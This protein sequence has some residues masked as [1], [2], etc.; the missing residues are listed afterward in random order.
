M[1]RMLYRKEPW[2]PGQKVFIASPAY[3][4]YGA[5]FAWSL[6]QTTAALARAGIPFELALYQG[7][8]HVDDSRNRLT[9]DFLNSDC[10]DMVFLDA[11]VGWQPSDFRALIDYERDIVAGVY[12]KKSGD[13]A[14]PVKLLPGEIWSDRDGLIEVAGAPTG[15]LRISRAV[16][17]TLAAR[18]Q[19]YN[20]KNDGAYATPL[21]FERQVHDMTRWGGDYVFCRKAREAGFSIYIDPKFRFEHSGEHTWTGNVGAWLR[22]RAGIG[23]LSGLTAVAKGR[24]TIDDIID[25]HD[26]WANPFAADPILL[27]GL[28]ALARAAKGPIL[29][30]G[31]G[32][33]TLVMAAAN[34]AVRVVCL[35]NS[36]V[37]AEHLRQEAARY[38]LANIDI[39]CAPLKD[40]WYDVGTL[41]EEDWALAVIDG[42][43]RKDGNRLEA[44]TRLALSRT[45]IVADDVQEDGGVVG[46]IEALDPTHTVMM[47]ETTTARKFAVAA[48]KAKTDEARAA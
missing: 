42:P 25:M 23:L 20:A 27:A 3:D 36:P 8:C 15:F 44:M 37:F 9:R 39:L 18:A 5:G 7:N 48:P 30:C 10:S 41:P 40:G 43:P 29:E 12:P 14:Y 38:S 28:A 19:L 17:E 33:S 46:V 34:S 45:V 13:D 4:Q 35:E 22:Q 1:A 6:A 32:L 24:E 21:I 2:A 47:F 11:D 16:M 31:S 26:A